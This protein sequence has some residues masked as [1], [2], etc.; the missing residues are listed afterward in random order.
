M[1]IKVRKAVFPVGGLGTRFL[2]ATKCMPKEMLPVVD[3]PLVQYAFEEARDAGIEQFIFVIGRHKNS[4]SDH[5]DHAYELQR[6][7]DEKGK[8]EELRQTI[9]WLPEPGAISFTRQINPLGLGHAIW[10]ARHLVGDE[11]FAV[12]LPDDLVLSE[13]PCLAQMIE[14]YN[15]HPLSHVVAT[16]DVP[17]EKTSSYGI[18]D[19]ESIKDGLVKA[20]TLVEK[21]KPEVAPS[22]KAITG[23]YILQPNIFGYLDNLSPGAGGEIQLTDALRESLRETTLY[24]LMYEGK[25]YD[26]GN[27]AGFLEANLAYSLERPDLRDKARDI[28]MK[29]YEQ[30]FGSIKKRA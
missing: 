16:E 28:I 17:P 3:K 15:Q 23:R 6:V 11:P 30:E 27:K 22:T 24:G 5:F 18:L 2:P 1:T 21:P 19:V 25:R 14:A 13:K 20:R 29:Y 12:L 8:E 10:C 26:C 7:L 4:I 9:G